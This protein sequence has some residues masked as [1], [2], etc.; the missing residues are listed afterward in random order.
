MYNHYEA[1]DTADNLYVLN[2]LIPSLKPGMSEKRFFLDFFA[3]NWAKDWADPAAQPELVYTDDDA[4]PYGNLSPT[5]QN[6]NMAGGA[7]SW[8]ESTPDDWAAC[9]YQVTPQAGCPYLQ[10]EVDGAAG[11]QLGIN[12]MAAKTSAPAMCCARRP[13]AKTTCAP[14]RRPA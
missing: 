14:L 1:C 12:L 6:V 10:A 3:A 8:T 2:T 13:S 11:A 4:S 9:Y 5:T 7:Q